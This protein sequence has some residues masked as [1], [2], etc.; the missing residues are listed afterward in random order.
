M[1]HIARVMAVPVVG[2]YWAEDRVQLV[3]DEWA[4]TLF[5]FFVDS[6]E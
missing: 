6:R 2:G 4:N 5:V 3:A 1:P